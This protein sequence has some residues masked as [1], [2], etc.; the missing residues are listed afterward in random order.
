MTKLKFIIKLIFKTLT[1]FILFVL[2]YLLAAFSISKIETKQ[3]K[4][5]EKIE[6]YILSNGVHTDIVLPTKNNE[7]D[8]SKFIPYETTKSTDSSYQFIAFGWG[9]KGFYL[10]TPTWGDLTFKV[11]FKAAFGLGSSAIHTTYHKEM[12]TGK[13]CRK[14]KISRNQYQKLITYIKNS[15]DLNKHQQPI[16]IPTN[17]VY[18]M[19][20]A[21]FEGTGTYNLFQT[22]NTWANNGLKSCGQKACLWTP[23]S[24][25]IFELYE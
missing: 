10:E 7:C 15:F 17:A 25:Y 12:K 20:D 8:W 5:S 18:G 19:N 4:I 21:F 14:I 16:F 6:I 9:D 2:T 23:F 22:C 24:G 11:A 1:V 3:H 13:D